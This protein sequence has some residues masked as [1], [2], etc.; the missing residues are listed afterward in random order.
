MLDAG[1]SLYPE[2]QDRW[3]ILLIKHTVCPAHCCPLMVVLWLFLA[4]V[5]GGTHPGGRPGCQSLWVPVLPR[6]WGEE[7]A[8][9]GLSQGLGWKISRGGGGQRCHQTRLRPHHLWT[10]ES[11]E[12]GVFPGHQDRRGAVFCMTIMHTRNRDQSVERTAKLWSVHL[13]SVHLQDLRQ[14][15]NF[16]LPGSTVSLSSAHCLKANV[17]LITWSQLGSMLLPGPCQNRFFGVVVLNCN[18]K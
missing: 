2:G 14:K 12:N 7:K 6:P 3:A 8:K 16:C 13:D 18:Q 17:N 5:L 4:G 15:W 10:G 9:A 1:S 11:W